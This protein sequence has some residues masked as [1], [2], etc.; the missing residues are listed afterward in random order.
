MAIVNPEKGTTVGEAAVKLRG[1]LSDRPQEATTEPTKAEEPVES[2]EGTEETQSDTDPTPRILKTKHG[3]REIEYQILS[4]ISDD[5]AEELRLGSMMLQDYRKKTSSISEKERALQS[6]AEKL[7]GKINDLEEILSFES[8]WLESDEAKELRDDDPDSYL[9][10]LDSIKGKAEKYQKYKTE[11][12][13]KANEKLKAQ[14]ETEVSKYKE[15][16]PEWLDKSKMDDDL[17]E[18]EKMLKKS[19]FDDNSIG[20]MWGIDHRLMSALRKAALF[21]VIQSKN[22][23]T[24]R[25][26]SVP[27][28]S[29]PGSV[30]ELTPEKTARQRKVEQA[31][32]SGK[33]RDAQAAIKELLG[34]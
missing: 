30:N 3:E 10:K 18:I 31:K 26:K 9:K 17:I 6:E 4:D 12:Q 16:I 34:G 8:N 11:Q 2:T 28:S 13:E 14:I 22:L 29:K 1:I 24:K 33:I 32:K 7:S 21:D 25:V 15:S 19:G 5:E 23:E 27:K 20:Q